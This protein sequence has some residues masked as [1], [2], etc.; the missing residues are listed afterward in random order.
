MHVNAYCLC[1]EGGAKWNSRAN[2]HMILIIPNYVYFRNEIYGVH[3]VHRSS[4]RSADFHYN[5]RGPTGLGN[6]AISF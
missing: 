6:G 5:E 2:A 1:V 4:K 3:H